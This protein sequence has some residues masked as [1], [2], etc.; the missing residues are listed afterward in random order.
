L[1]KKLHL[2]CF[3]VE[4]LFVSLLAKKLIGIGRRGFVLVHK[5]VAPE[6][7]TVG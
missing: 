1:E 5:E 4:F 7:W 3:A 2:F 6:I